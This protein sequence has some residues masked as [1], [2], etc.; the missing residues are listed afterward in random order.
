MA[1]RQQP[2]SLGGLPIQIDYAARDY[3]SIRSEML[4]LATRLLP[5]W[6]DREPADMGVL[7]VEAMSLVSDV[8]SYNLDRVQNESYLASAQTREAVVDLLRL[9]GYELAPAS[10]ATVAM[11]IKTNEDNVTLPQGFIVKT[12]ASATT[13]SLEYRLPAETTLDV[14]GYHCVSYEQGVAARRF[15]ATPSVNDDLV[16]VAGE[17]RTDLL[18]V[19]NGARSQS[20]LLPQSPVCLSVDGSASISVLAGNEYWEARTSFIGTDPNDK[21]FI[22]RFLSSQEVLITFGDG[23]NGAIPSIDDEIYASYRINGGAITNRAGVGAITSFDNVQG[24][25]LVYNIAQPTGGADPETIDNAKKQGPLSLRALDRCVTLED[26]ETMAALTPG[27]GVRAS[28][29]VQ[30]EN[31]LDVNIYVASEGTNPI[32]SGRWFPSLAAGY[33]VLGAVGRWL[34]TKKPVPTRLNVL[35][36]TP[37]YPY[38]RATIYL[39]DNVLRDTVVEDIDLGLQGLFATITDSFGSGVALSSLIQVI[40]NTRGVD[41]VDAFEFHRLPSARLIYGSE[42]AFDSATVTVSAFTV[43]TQRET[44]DIEWA[45]ETSYRLKTSSGS[46]MKDASNAVQVFSADQNN[47]VSFY[48]ADASD[49]EAERLE[50]FSILVARGGVAPTAGDI[51]QFSTDGY[52]GNID[53]R[54]YEIV[55]APTGADG[56]L[57]SSMFD[58]TFLGGIN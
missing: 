26:F 16:F 57:L 29:A 39:Y 20:F 48:N 14:A 33:G 9:I 5:E 6:T 37:I 50:Q 11:V 1:I 44:Y 55:V 54:P 45:T 51:W 31:N 58:L 53:A 19:S 25:E 13:T 2:K 18:G 24:V 4:K 10:P 15:G 7:M 23:V 35:A 47:V 46:Y 56:A 34:E 21:V 22:Y 40:E 42:D 30:G 3:D 8:L 49:V 38:L 41:F 43:Q 12:T 52:L 28:R 36:P 17:P 27:G 32:P